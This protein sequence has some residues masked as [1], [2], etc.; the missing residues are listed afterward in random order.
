M[1]PPLVCGA[2][3]SL[4]L[5]GCAVRPTRFIVYGDMRFTDRSETVASRPV[6][7]AALVARIAVEHPDALFLTGDVPWHGGSQDDYA[8]YRQETTSWRSEGLRVYPVLGNHEFQQCQES[9][10][11]EN[12]GNAFPLFRLHRWYGVDLGS[13]LRFLALDSDSSLLPGSDQA[14]WLKDQIAAL[15]RS[16]RFLF[17]LLHHPL[18]TDGDEG[19]RANEAALAAQLAVAARRARAHFVVCTGHVHN[20]ERFERDGMVLLVSG[21]GG[22]KPKPIARSS[23]DRYQK[24]EFPNFHYIRFELTSRGLRG[25]M[26][27]LADSESTNPVTWTVSDSFQIR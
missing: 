12:W 6:P 3:V 2:L 26:V 27:R 21:G 15:P 13:K 8:V 24:N 5:A 23:A 4:L 1:T 18:M 22:A 7:R 11:L 14:Q 19:I 20:Y 25:E 9:T 17:I 16:V 10:C